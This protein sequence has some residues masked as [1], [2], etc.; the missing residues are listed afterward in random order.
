MSDTNTRLRSHA[1]DPRTVRPVAGAPNQAADVAQLSEAKTNARHRSVSMLEVQQTFPDIIA[2]QL[3]AQLKFHAWTFDDIVITNTKQFSLVVP[4]NPYRRALILCAKQV[5]NYGYSFGPP[6]LGT[7]PF[8]A[9]RIMRFYSMP[10]PSITNGAKPDFYGDQV[11]PIDDI[12]L[13]L[14]N[15][16]VLT[17]I[18]NGPVIY[19][20]TLS[21]EDN[22]ISSQVG[23]RT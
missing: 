23:P 15:Q 22:Q 11:C 4:R 14:V 21:M 10:F 7:V 5:L 2:R 20:G 12:Y 8:G 19:E 13:V 16:G 3:P 6:L 9:G 17:T 1:K 18:L